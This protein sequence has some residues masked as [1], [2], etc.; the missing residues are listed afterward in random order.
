[1]IN[2]HDEDGNPNGI[3]GVPSDYK[4]AAQPL[5]PWGQTE[6]PPNAPPGTDLESYWDTNTV[7]LKLNN[8]KTQRATYNTSLPPWRNQ[9][10]PGPRQWFQDASLFKIVR[11]TEKLNLRFNVDFFNVFNNPNNPTSVAANGVLATRNSGSAAR[12]TQLTVRLSW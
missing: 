9:Y 6:L 11:L 8:G 7:W 3:M 1:L 10:S 5:I 2:S 12:T 4:P